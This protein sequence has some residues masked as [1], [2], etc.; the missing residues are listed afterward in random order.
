[1]EPISAWKKPDT[2][3][4]SVLS[5]FFKLSHTLKDFN[6]RLQEEYG[7]P[8]WGSYALFTIGTVFVGAALGLML[9]CVVD[10]VYPPKKLQRQSFSESKGISPHDDI[11]DIANDEI[12]D[13][14]PQYDDDAEEDDE[15]AV[16]E[17]DEDENEN[18]NDNDNE[19]VSTEDEKQTQSESEEPESEKKSKKKAT[20][21]NKSSPSEVRKRKPRKAD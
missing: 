4:M 10:F 1:M 6:N 18:D 15:E 14:R 17:D 21:D 16:D 2:L 8:T 20:D 3:H 9:V 12:E 11:E 19:N 7:L 5:Y 13:D